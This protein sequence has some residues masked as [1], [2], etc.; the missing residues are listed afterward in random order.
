MV[1]ECEVEVQLD[2]GTAFTVHCSCQGTAAT[3]GR[4]WTNTTFQAGLKTLGCR[5]GPPQYDAERLRRDDKTVWLIRR[6][7][8]QGAP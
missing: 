8:W 5:L 2:G 4:E 3:I 6:N 1:A 7:N